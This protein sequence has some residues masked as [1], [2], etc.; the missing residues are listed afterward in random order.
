MGMYSLPEFKFPLRRKK[1]RTGVIASAVFLSIFFGFLAGIV[2]S[3]FF[4]I[5]I[6]NYLK[7]LNIEPISQTEEVVNETGYISQNSQ[8]QAIIEAV[9]KSSP[10]VV[11]IL[12]EG[13]GGG[14]G[15]IVSEDGLILT[16]KHVVFDDDAE[17]TVFT[18]N[19]KKFSAK[20]LAKD[21]FQDL[22]I[23][24]IDQENNVNENGELVVNKFPV[25]TLGDSDNIERGQ[26]VIAIGNALAEFRN[27]VSSGLISGLGRRITASGGTYVETLDDV[28]QTDTAINKGNSGGPLLNLRG[29]VIGINTAIANNAQSIGFSIPINYA[30]RDIEQIQ[31]TGKIVYPFIGVRYVL[32]NEEVKEER[33]LTVNYGVLIVEG[34]PWQPAITSGSPAEQ[35]GL[36]EGDIILSLDGK[37]ITENN[38]LVKI[39]MRY[40]AGDEVTLKVLR[41]NQDMNIVLTLSE[42]FE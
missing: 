17:Y 26:T 12:I 29:E 23:V 24:K 22:A 2:S 37:D 31:E 34:D 5:R 40:R 32:V 6:E 13:V 19:G 25:L 9:K 15:F 27:T 39:L 3:G 8:E 11:S 33:K 21:P 1:K 14:T 28:I 30:K 35:V 20:V 41:D 36:E 7:G 42:R 10:A 4:Y 16:N 18:N 38:S